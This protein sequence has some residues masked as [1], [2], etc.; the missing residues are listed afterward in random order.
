MTFASL[1]LGIYI[2]Y[3]LRLLRN[4]FRISEPKTPIS[5]II[6]SNFEP[7]PLLYPVIIPVLVALSLADNSE[8]FLLPNIILSLSSLPPLS[9]PCN[10]TYHGLSLAHWAVTIIPVIFSENDILPLEPAIPLCLRNMDS[11][12]LFLIFP[13]QQ[14]LLPTLNFLLTTSLLPAELQLLSTALINVVLFSTS[15]QAEILKALL[16]LGGVSCFVLC[17]R[18]LNWE[19]ALA[20]VPTWKFRR[21]DHAWHFPQSILETLDLKVCQRLCRVGMVNE[22][23]SDSESS[24]DYRLVAR[25]N[26]THQIL[27]PSGKDPAAFRN[28]EIHRSTVLASTVDYAHTGKASQEE[29]APTETL[30]R[31][32][33]FSNFESANMQLRRA[34]TTPS[35]RRKRLLTP[36]VQSFLSLT[37]AQAQVRKWAY[38]LYA[39]VAILF[40]ILGPVRSYINK[41]ALYG[42]EPFGWAAGYLFG[43]IPSFRFWLVHADLERWVLIPRRHDRGDSCHLGW[44]E[45]LR[46]DTFGEANTRLLI[47]AY[48]G[49][50]LFA[51]ILIVLQLSSVVE[52][53]TRRKVF[54]GMMVVMFLPTIFIDPNFIALALVLVLA[55]FLLLDLFRASQLPPISKPL[56]YFLAPYVDGRDHRGPVIVSHIFLLIGCAIPLWLS[57]SGVPRLGSQPWEG[58]EV[59]SRD[60]GM[61]SGVICVGMGDSAASLIGRRYGR[62]KWLWGGGKSLEGS[63][64]FAAAVCVGLIMARFWLVI[65]GWDNAA[66]SEVSWGVM[67]AKSLLAA[68]GASTTE[69]VLTGGNDNVIVPVVL[70][71]LV[72]GLEI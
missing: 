35:G 21:P 43:D 55:I 26:G 2:L 25:R 30:H 37:V 5:S 65:G 17:R 59:G 61:V 66:R 52:V 1:V 48:Y 63:A 14:A 15:P 40:V 22:D 57:L 41:H 19:V 50:V 39:Y 8:A 18:V 27:K 67:I 23:S 64:A 6:P 49:V 71:L 38:A 45:H 4:A 32:H 3:P 60:V 7:A 69:A 70:W 9:V 20:R 53:D 13:L 16:W 29:I 28:S 10:G 72:R 56:T 33:T 34:Q 44:V 58:W 36:D 24:N 46:L 68:V 31:R 51:G 62:L 47:S 12:A 11:E 54:H 42:N